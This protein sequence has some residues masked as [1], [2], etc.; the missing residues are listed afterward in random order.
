MGMKPLSTF[1]LITYMLLTSNK[2]CLTRVD[3]PHFAGEA[4]VIPFDGLNI[5]IYIYQ[6]F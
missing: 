4:R 2:Q 6:I 5:Y 3:G 1:S